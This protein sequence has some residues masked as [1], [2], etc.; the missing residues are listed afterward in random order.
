MTAHEPRIP[1][2]DNDGENNAIIAA[3]GSAVE[4]ARGRLVFMGL[5]FVLAYLGMGA[6]ATWLCVLQQGGE[7]RFES[8]TADQGNAAVLAAGRGDI[9]D[10]NG[11]L[12]A[13]TLET[14]SL[15]ADP[16]LIAD[17]AT[18]AH[19]LKSV[20]PR[21]DEAQTLKKLS[22]KGRFIWIERGITPDEMKA[23]TSLGH[24]GLDFRFENRRFYP[25]EN[26]TAHL[27]GYTDIS[28]DGLAGVERSFDKALKNNPKPLKL[29]VDVRFQHALRDAMQ[30]AITDFTAKGAAGA[31]VDVETGEVMAAASLPDFNPQDMNAAT[32]DQKFN[33]FALGVYEMGS[34]F[35]TFTTAALLDRVDPSLGQKFDASKPL[36]RGRFKINDYHA[37]NTILTVPEIFMHSSNIGT[38]L[39]GEKIGTSGL[40]G[41]FGE[42]GLEQPV[43]IALPEK[44][45]PLVPTPWRDIST[46]TASYGHGISVTPLHLIRAFSAIVNGGTLPALHILKGEHDEMRPRVVSEQTSE[47]MRRLLRL[48]VTD[49]TAK[50]GNLPGVLLAGK[51][52]TSEKN[53]NGRYVKNQ[54][55]SSFVGTFPADHPR[56]AILISVDEPHGNKKSYGYATA[57]WV[58]V[59]PVAE[60]AA[61]IKRLDSMPPADT[62]AYDEPLIKEMSQYMPLEKKET[63][64]RLATF[65]R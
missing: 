29:S 21:I 28:G 42:L 51:T 1:E 36:V 40:K 3:R 53:V 57:G 20:F 37:K 25:Q 8:V 24:P 45:A 62:V 10:R 18:V 15:F 56:Y 27:I 43:P 23:V 54:L 60:V 17:P 26:L 58:A 64:A 14:I 35:K 65:E 30:K 52:G 2:N 39:M 47:K 63:Q 22:G 48:V 19:D 44:A 33:R 49:G 11:V 38:A 55:V 12:L 50:N 31:I 9:V 61:A 59:P 13:T 4:T 5:M 32:D 7:P 46:V 16:K 6:R 41:F 34:T